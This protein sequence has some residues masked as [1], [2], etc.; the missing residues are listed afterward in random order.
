MTVLAK[1]LVVDDTADFAGALAEARE[2]KA[3]RDDEWLD[4]ALRRLRALG[5]SPDC[6]HVNKLRRSDTIR[7]RA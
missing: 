1:M 5:G 4:A 2:A 6:R 7:K 3:A